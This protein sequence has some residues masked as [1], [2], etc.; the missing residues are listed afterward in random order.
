MIRHLS[1]AYWVPSPEDRD[2]NEDR[3]ALGQKELMVGWVRM[4]HS[5][6]SCHTT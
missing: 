3:I 1:H 6:R 4:S 5:A 2:P